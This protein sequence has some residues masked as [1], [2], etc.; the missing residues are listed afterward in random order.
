MATLIRIDE[1]TD[2]E[3]RAQASLARLPPAD[4]FVTT[5]LKPW[6]FSILNNENNGEKYKNAELDCVIVCPYGILAVELKNHPGN[7]TPR[8]SGKW[9]GLN[10]DSD[11]IRGRRKKKDNP[12]GQ[13][14]DESFHLKDLV[15]KCGEISIYAN[16]LIVLSHRQA[17]LNWEDS[18]VLANS[19]YRLRVT[20]IDN[21]ENAIKALAGGK[22]KVSSE[23]AQIVVSCLLD[24]SAER[25]DSVARKTLLETIVNS[26]SGRKPKD[27]ARYETTLSLTEEQAKNG[28]TVEVAFGTH[29]FEFVTPAGLTHGNKIRL[30][31]AIN[32]QDAFATVSIKTPS[33]S[34]NPAPSMPSAPTHHRDHRLWPWMI[35]LG[36]VALLIYLH[37]G[38][39][40]RPPNPEVRKNVRLEITANTEPYVLDKDTDLLIEPS[41]V[42][43]VKIES[44]DGTF[45]TYRTDG[46]MMTG[47]S[48]E[49]SI[50]I[51]P[52]SQFS[53]KSCTES[54]Y[55]E[56]E[57][58][59]DG[60]PPNAP[61]EHPVVV[62]PPP[63]ADFSFKICNRTN[64]MLQIAL[65]GRL[66]EQPDLWIVKGWAKV[67][68]GVCG[69]AG[70]YLKGNFYAVARGP[71]STQWGSNDIQL[72]VSNH[73]FQRENTPGYKCLNGEIPIGFQHFYIPLDA[74]TWTL[75]GNMPLIN[76]ESRYGY[77]PI[78]RSVPSPSFSVPFGR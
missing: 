32:G 12:Y 2:A 48:K 66:P 62:Q 15:G 5:N 74:Y 40:N 42:K 39:Q 56:I 53:I 75:T 18:D 44:N 60:T 63:K 77:P 21:A 28:S 45:S 46:S 4:W 70:N 55:L 6:R 41:R 20:K 50:N 58:V 67:P 43:A 59:K 76:R 3:Q 16:F 9:S 33:Y 64:V 26:Y 10:Y 25:F 11:A 22:V 38:E 72:C 71:D 73:M 24:M 69:I 52:G 57:G 7:V 17:L 37:G 65:S 36:V 23:D 47:C 27:S 68:A 13:A 19:E 8:M 1:G 30:G 51:S 54:V 78:A 34:S 29:R 35:G 61:V 14:L 49:A 31:N